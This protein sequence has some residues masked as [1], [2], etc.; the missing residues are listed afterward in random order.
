MLFKIQ[1][2]VNSKYIE[3]LVALYSTKLLQ[4]KTLAGWLLFKLVG[5]S[6]WQIKCY[7]YAAL[8]LIL[9]NIAIITA[10]FYCYRKR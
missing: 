7:V 3:L 6:F 9:H 5:Q 1:L 10:L 4:Q 8:T 2:A